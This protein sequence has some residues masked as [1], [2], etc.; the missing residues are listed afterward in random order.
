[1][2]GGP[3]VG[4]AHEHAHAGIV[5]VPLEPCAMVTVVGEALIEKLL[6]GVEVG[7]GVGVGLGVVVGVGVGVGLGGGVGV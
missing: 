6:A 7:V 2:P 3:V 5:L 1:M 4:S